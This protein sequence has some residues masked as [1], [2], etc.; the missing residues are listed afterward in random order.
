MSNQKNMSDRI[1]QLFKHYTSNNEPIDWGYI[2]NTL[3]SDDKKFNNENA[4]KMLK[5][6]NKYKVIPEIIDG[7]HQCAFKYNEDNKVY[8]YVGYLEFVSDLYKSRYTFGSDENTGIRKAVLKYKELCHDH[9]VKFRINTRTVFNMYNG[10]SKEGM[11]PFDDPL[12]ESTSKELDSIIKKVDDIISTEDDGV[13]KS[14]I[15]AL[16][17]VNDIT[18]NN[19]IVMDVFEKHKTFNNFKIIL[20]NS[21]FPYVKENVVRKYTCY[22]NFTE[23]FQYLVNN[24]RLKFVYALKEFIGNL[25]HAEFR[26]YLSKMKTDKCRMIFM[27]IYGFTVFTDEFINDTE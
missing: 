19:D 18:V 2:F 23:T 11:L 17:S 8:L 20:D 13:F 12:E 24:H 1:E 14:T 16:N 10:F 27:K 3:C 7:I 6:C 22:D 5:L 21:P 9:N 4:T 15:N 26:L 25:T